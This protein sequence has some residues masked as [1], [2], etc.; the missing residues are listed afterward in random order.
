MSGCLKISDPIR[1]CLSTEDPV[2]YESQGHTAARRTWALG[3]QSKLESTYVSSEELSFSLA[4]VFEIPASFITYFS[5][6]PR[7]N[8]SIA[9]REC[10]ARCMILGLCS[11]PF[12]EWAVIHR[13]TEFITIGTQRRKR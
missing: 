6:G 7:L 3:F 9:S 4:L 11:A 5:A 2:I 1:L 8:L 13:F 10:S 12:R